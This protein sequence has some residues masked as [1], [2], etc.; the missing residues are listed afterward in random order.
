LR[1][2][3]IR[4]VLGILNA[5]GVLL[6]VNLCWLRLSDRL[7]GQVDAPEIVLLYAVATAVVAIV[8]LAIAAF[9]VMARS[10]AAWW[11]AIPAVILC[12][13]IISVCT[14]ASDLDPDQRH[15]D[16]TGAGRCKATICLGDNEVLLFHDELEKGADLDGADRPTGRGGAIRGWGQHTPDVSFARLVRRPQRT[17]RHAR[18]TGTF[19]DDGLAR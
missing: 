17:P 2:L 7:A 5:F 1:Q 12:A 16:Q 14:V 19:V 9:A 3:A 6:G 11:L 15:A 4:T 13:A 10:V 8:A 18:D